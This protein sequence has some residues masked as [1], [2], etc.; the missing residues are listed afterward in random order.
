[1]AG[2]LPSNRVSFASFEDDAFTSAYSTQ[3]ASRLM[4]LIESDGRTEV[5][6]DVNL[7]ARPS[8][9]LVSVCH[10]LAEIAP[11]SPSCHGS[12]TKLKHGAGH[13]R[14][15]PKH[16]DFRL[17]APC[18]S[19]GRAVA[20]D[21]AS[22]SNSYP[23]DVPAAEM[24]Q[25]N[26]REEL[27]SSP[28]PA[29]TTN[30]QA[31]TRFCSHRGRPSAIPQAQLDGYVSELV[32]DGIMCNIHA[33]LSGRRHNGCIIGTP[34]EMAG[35]DTL[36][37]SALRTS[38]RNV[39]AKRP[40][41][42]GD[43]Y[44]IDTS[45]IAHILDIVIA[46][47]HDARPDG[48]RSKYQ[49]LFF[50][51]GIQAKP[52]LQTS[53]ILL[54]SSA[55][56]DPATT[57]CSPRPYFSWSGCSEEFGNLYA[58]AKTAYIS[59]QSVTGI[60]WDIAHSLRDKIANTINGKYN[61][62]LSKSHSPSRRQSSYFPRPRQHTWPQPLQGESNINSQRVS[63]ELSPCHEVSNP[64]GRQFRR[65]SQRS[66]SE[67]LLGYSPEQQTKRLSGTVSMTSFPRLKSRSCTNDWLTPL[68]L[69][70][71]SEYEEPEFRRQT[72][73]NLYSYGVDAHL[74]TPVR[75]QLPILEEDS[76]LLA[77]P[78][79]A[80]ET[81]S[82]S[83]DSHS[84][85]PGYENQWLCEVGDKE[86]PDG[87]RF[88]RSIGSAA[89]R[90]I[91][92]K[93]PADELKEMDQGLV[94]RLRRYSFIPLLEQTPRYLRR[95]GTASA[96][97]VPIPLVE[98]NRVNKEEKARNRSLLQNILDWADSS[99][100]KLTNSKPTAGMDDQLGDS[101]SH[102]HRYGRAPCSEETTP[103]VCMDELWTP[104]SDQSLQCSEG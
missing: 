42:E 4:S 68:G 40:S 20:R 74:G 90:R 5:P 19:F 10:T 91:S 77:P 35:E 62:F 71:E 26:T 21:D 52:S 63:F 92:L 102:R 69:A 98:C 84:T 43:Y 99:A 93:A 15:S 27:L 87:K 79:P 78:S 3:P 82:S 64:L 86:E 55:A 38:L 61:L 31:T 57:I 103:H 89:H 37:S 16:H 48:N 12:D 9:P 47:I 6:E 32:I 51:G 13:E 11:S 54:G 88:G 75:S 66:T 45:D 53:K 80:S 24:N 2:F 39:Y 1:M 18:C 25:N 67:P 60:N 30:D 29:V 65:L 96:P 100:D 58:G 76:Q 36:I 50:H 95:A 7:A 46:G 59:R 70:D 73:A 101:S 94:D 81:E 44:L 8:E 83:V 104:W 22:P 33:F 97:T 14:H 49:S 56:A 28:A 41:S 23:R 17:T 34:T 85:F 72:I